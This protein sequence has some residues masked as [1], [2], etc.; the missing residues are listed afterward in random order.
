M[1]KYLRPAEVAQILGVSDRH[2]RR[3]ILQKMTHYRLGPRS[4]RAV[5]YTHLADPRLPPDPQPRS[6]HRWGDD[7]IS[8]WRVD[9][10]ARYCDANS[11]QLTNGFLQVCTI[12][13][14]FRFDIIVQNSNYS[15]RRKQFRR[16]LFGASMATSV[17][18]ARPR[19]KGAL[20]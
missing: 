6:S 14:A 15:I 7:K 17:S 20:K 4:I 16:V 9:V 3:L 1:T 13:G 5:S 10:I 2:A 19:C 18:L 8:C 11:L 12:C